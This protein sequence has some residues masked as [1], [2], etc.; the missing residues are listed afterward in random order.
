MARDPELMLHLLPER[1]SGSHDLNLTELLAAMRRRVDESM[2]FS[3]VMTIG[4][5]IDL[6]MIT[7]L[8]DSVAGRAHEVL[9]RQERQTSH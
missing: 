8:K 9:Q 6:R 4:A 1:T 3:A 7:R 5:S 2:R